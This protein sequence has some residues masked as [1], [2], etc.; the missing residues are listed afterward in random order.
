VGGKRMRKN[1]KMLVYLLTVMMVSVLAFGS[2]YITKAEGTTENPTVTVIGSNFPGIPK[3]EGN[4]LK[5]DPPVSETY[6]VGNNEV[7]VTFNEDKTK[8]S[9]TSNNPVQHVFVKGGMGGGGNLFTYNPTA[10]SGTNLYALTNKQGIPQQIS[11]V[12][13]YFT[14]GETP[15]FGRLIVNK[16]YDANG[17]G[18]KDEN[19]RELLGWRIGIEYVEGGEYSDIE[20]YETEYNYLVAEGTYRITE[21]MPVEAGWIATT[22]VER[23]VE[24]TAGETSTVSFGN[25]AIGDGGGRTI[26]FWSNKN[27]ERTISSNDTCKEIV[28]NLGGYKN[29]RAWILGASAVDM[30]YMLEAQMTAMKLNV[31]SGFVASDRDIWTGVDMGGGVKVINVCELI[32]K[33]EGALEDEEASRSYLEFLKDLLDDANN[34]KNFVQINPGYTFPELNDGI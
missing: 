17:N 27:G 34:N 31:A 28:N 23:V 26:G 1:L 30:K 25:I 3:V 20:Y 5:I 11:H 4:Y 2:G 19:E 6:T 32:A 21:F 8:V 10:T 18:I 15:V 12:D 7:T 29:F 13:F 16:F 24:V 14:E 22:A 9:W 33:A